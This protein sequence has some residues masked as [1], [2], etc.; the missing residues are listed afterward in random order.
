[1][2]NNVEKYIEANWDECIKENKED[3]GDLIGLPYPYTV[4]AVGFFDSLFYWDTYFLNQGLKHSK[5]YQ[6]IKN[7]TNNMLF[8]VEKY[9]FMPNG[10]RTYYLKN[11]QPP[12][13]SEMVRDVYDFYHD[14][15]WLKEAYR[16][17]KIEYDFWMTRRN[18]ETGLNQYNAECPEEDIEIVAEGFLKRI[19]LDLDMSSEKLAKQYLTACESGWDLTPRWGLNAED[20]IEVDLNSILYI[21]EKNMEFFSKEIDAGEDDLWSE[22]AEKRRNLMNEYMLY[23][24]LF[25]DYNF[26]SHK[27]GKVFSVASYYPLYAGLATEEQAKAAVENLSRL[28]EKYGVLSCEKNDT[29]GRYQWDAPHGWACLQYIMVY[30]LD[31]YGYFEA[32]RRI[33]EK[34]VKLVEKIFDET[35]NLWEKYNVIEG[36][37]NTTVKMPPMMGWSAGTYTALKEYISDRN[38]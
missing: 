20:Y 9:G 34:Y 5:R 2:I 33:A 37:T 12:F 38:N 25:L 11:S 6:Q 21:M 36:N 26:K 1:M 19:K 31:R 16:I 23:D 13:L 7:N 17:L 27:F 28:E 10:N 14:K 18:T 8:L 22:R 35:Q 4:P 24:G 29:E 30:G 3:N 32:A 15:I